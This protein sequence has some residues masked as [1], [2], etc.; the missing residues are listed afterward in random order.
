MSRIQLPG[1]RNRI[2]STWKFM[3]DPYVTYRQWKQKYGETF[4]VRAMN[5][6]IVATSNPENIRR[7]FA[8]PSS[9]LKQFAVETVKPLMG[10]S[11][12]I[13]THGE[14]H[15]RER[16]LV[17]PSFHGERIA[18][19]ADIVRDVARRAGERWRMGDRV[20]M[21]DVTLDISLEVIIRVVFGVQSQDRIEL[22]KE[23]I[24]RFV[25][26]FH[27]V[28]AFSRLLHRPLLGLSPWN[29]FVKGRDEFHALLDDEIAKR[30]GAATSPDLLSRLL[31]SKDENGQPIP[32]NRIRDQL[33]TMLLA[34]HETT[35]IAMAWAMSWLH[36]NP[37]VL[38]KLAGELSSLEDSNEILKH[39]YLT[40]VCNESLRLNSVVSDIARKITEPIELVDTT[41]PADTNISLAICLV[42]ENPELYPEPFRFNPER[43]SERQ[44]KPH[45]FLPFGGGIRRCIGASLAMLEM[46]MT[47]AT[48]VKEYEFMLPDDAPESEV[49]YRRNITMAPKSGIPLIFLGRTRKPNASPTVS[50]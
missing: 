35:Q 7:I 36:R 9:A 12:M 24:S 6:D 33:V 42:H 8:M 32:H 34:G 45:E 10:E 46:K 38:T 50:A 21:M 26:G 30:R 44:F 19:Q 15:R 20:R 2:Y 5:G 22:F 18:N 16:A 11:S 13:I 40:G 41:L 47:I 28:L 14:P 43:W 39:P 48:W 3:R 4:L 31:E 29:R 27:P 23:T 49:T 17:S 1:P 37:D 25:S